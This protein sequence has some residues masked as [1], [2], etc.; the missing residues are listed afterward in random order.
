MFSRWFK[1]AA[2]VA[3]CV[4]LSACGAAV[5]TGT[6]APL[7]LLPTTRT[8]DVTWSAPYLEGGGTFGTAGHQSLGE[9]YVA[10]IVHWLGALPRL[11]P[12]NAG[13]GACPYA[14]FYG[15]GPVF[16]FHT[17]A[18]TVVFAYQDCYQVTVT[19]NGKSRPTLEALD[20]S[21]PGSEQF[22]R[23]ALHVQPPAAPG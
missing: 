6:I 15:S 20:P 16:T 8:V 3:T 21:L 2:T 9:P 10:T 23:Q 11:N 5:S 13:Q 4:A 7:A 17:T 1:G 22:M 18:G 14:L 19:I 12:S